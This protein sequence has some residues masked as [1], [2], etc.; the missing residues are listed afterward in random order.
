MDIASLKSLGFFGF[1]TVRQIIADN[2]NGVPDRKGVYVI[3]RNSEK[4]PEFLPNNVGGHFKG[5]NP[6][7]SIEVLKSNWV[8]NSNVIYIG[9][10]GGDQ[11]SAT[12]KKRIKQLLRFSQGEPV[13]HWGGR[14]LWQLKDHNDFLICWKTIENV[15]SR[16]V[17][18]QLIQDFIGE[19][20]KRPFANLMD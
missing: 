11:S 13:G 10:A 16:D 3:I 2:Y 18:K 15:D 14:Y 9:K 7:V 6:S 4:E 5:K 19:Y 8:N 12:L 17:E 20:K 1:K